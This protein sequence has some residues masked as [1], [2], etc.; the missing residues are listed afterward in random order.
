LLESKEFEDDQERL[1]R[2]STLIALNLHMRTSKK[3]LQ[4]LTEKQRKMN[5]LFEQDKITL[6]DIREKLADKE[7]DE[8]LLLVFKKYNNLKG[9]ERD[10]FYLKIESF[11]PQETRN[12]L[13]E[14]NH[15]QITRAISTLMKEC[16]RM[17]T[18]VEIANKT[19]LSRQTVHKHLKEY[20]KDERYLETLAQFRFMRSKVLAK[21]FSFAV[22][23]DTKAAKLFF[24][25]T[26]GIEKANGAEGNITNTQNNYIQVNQVRLSQESIEQLS[27]DQLGQLE[28]ILK[29]V[30]KP[31]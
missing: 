29:T 11:I 3:S 10:L 2:I 24:E 6:E 16:G 30:L 31:L 7:R 5:A 13:W 4:K 25:V 17:P 8:F 27:V 14:Y 23:G 19:E 20:A 26:G 1:E 18:N 9:E 15:N 21:V 28:V 12:Q 22:K